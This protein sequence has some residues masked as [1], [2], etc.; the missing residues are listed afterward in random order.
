MKTILFLF[1][2]S[3]IKAMEVPQPIE[4]PII[5]AS[6]KLPVRYIHSHNRIVPLQTISPT[7]V[8]IDERHVHYARNNTVIDIDVIRKHYATQIKLIETKKQLQDHKIN[9]AIARR[10]TKIALLTSIVTGLGITATLI[11]HF[12]TNRKC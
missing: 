10:R 6:Q 2:F 7:D 12:T 1:S 4:L 8:D 9:L 3:I 11:V 5:S